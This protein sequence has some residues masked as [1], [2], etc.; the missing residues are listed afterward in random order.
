MWKFIV[1][2]ICLV[3]SALFSASETA[4]TSISKIRVRQLVENKVKGAARVENL[5]D[6]PSKM[7]SAILIGNNIVNIGASSLATAIT[8]DIYGS[9]GVGIATGA[10]TLLILIFGEITP[11]SLA[12]QKSEAVSLRLSKFVHIVSILVD[13]KSVV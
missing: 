7:L 13:R 6:N 9:T 10:M 11:K 12:A 1:L 3:F 5:L 2:L 4:L 8:I